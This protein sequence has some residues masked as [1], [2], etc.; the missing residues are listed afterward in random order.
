MSIRQL[1]EFVSTL[2][3]DSHK[4]PGNIYYVIRFVGE[5]LKKKRLL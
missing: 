4:Y 2:F 3:L 1:D 5:S